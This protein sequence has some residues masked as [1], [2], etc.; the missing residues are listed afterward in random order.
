M[1]HRLNMLLIEVPSSLSEKH[2]ACLSI[3]TDL[4]PGLVGEYLMSRLLNADVSKISTTHAFKCEE[5]NN[6][7][8]NYV[9]FLWYFIT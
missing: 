5:A 1:G 9:V 3:P 6:Y 4:K 7:P 2:R 8:K